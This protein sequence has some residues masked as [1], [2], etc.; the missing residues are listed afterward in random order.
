MVK[1][2]LGDKSG[3][4]LTGQERGHRV[5]QRMM[6]AGTYQKFVSDIVERTLREAIQQ[7]H[8]VSHRDTRSEVGWSRMWSAVSHKRGTFLK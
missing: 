7:E 3:D 8:C 1:A 6:L 2:I 4:G 5:E